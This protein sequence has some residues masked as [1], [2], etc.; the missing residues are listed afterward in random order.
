MKNALLRVLL[1]L[2]EGTRELRIKPDQALFDHALEEISC[3][4]P[5]G[6]VEDQLAI[7]FE[8]SVTYHVTIITANHLL[9]VL[10]PYHAYILA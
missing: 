5:V 7:E 10:T 6:W 8:P 1:F 9:Q 3:V 2:K 4:T